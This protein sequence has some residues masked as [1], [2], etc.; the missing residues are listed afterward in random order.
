MTLQ[1][2]RCFAGYLDVMRALHRAYLLEPAGSHGVWGLDD[3]HCLP[4]LW[5][6]AQLA[7]HA[8]IPPDAVN[9]EEVSSVCIATAGQRLFVSNGFSTSFPSFFFY[10]NS[11]RADSVPSLWRQ[12]DMR[13]PFFQTV[14]CMTSLQLWCSLKGKVLQC[15][16]SIAHSR[17]H[18]CAYH[19][20]AFNLIGDNV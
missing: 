20:L 19:V 2:L 15:M 9:D 13:A 1:V 6:A 14:Y 12:F 4:F 3:Y 7:E 18:I 11:S 5:G 17:V 8:T 16:P 10:H